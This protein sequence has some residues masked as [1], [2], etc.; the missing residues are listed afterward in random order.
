MSRLKVVISE[1]IMNRRCYINMGMVLNYGK[2]K[3]W[4]YAYDKQVMLLLLNIT[5][6]IRHDCIKLYQIKSL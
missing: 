4:Y 3:Y 6:E 5:M 1:V 2:G